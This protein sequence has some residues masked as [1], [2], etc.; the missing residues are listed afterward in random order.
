LQSIT[1]VDEKDQANGVPGG[2][3]VKIEK[4]EKPYGIM[5]TN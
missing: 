2:L 5:S 1:L 4:I 3:I